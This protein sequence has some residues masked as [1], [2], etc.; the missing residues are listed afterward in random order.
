M[1]LPVRLAAVAGFI[2]LMALCAQVAVPM[3]PAPMTLQTFPVAALIAGELGRRPMFRR[4]AGEAA[5]MVGAHLLILAMG[6]AWLATSLGLAEALA[7]GFTP[8]L[9][10]GLVKSVAVVAC[11]TALRRLA[12]FRP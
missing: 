9:I 4:P 3:V 8:F 7:N 10:G 12:P 6:A 5:L 1:S 2:L 11:A